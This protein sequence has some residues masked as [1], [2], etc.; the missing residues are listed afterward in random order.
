[1]GGQARIFRM[2]DHRKIQLCARAQRFAHDGFIED[3]LAVVRDSYCACF[4]QAAKI[5]QHGTFAVVG[6]GCD[7]ENINQGAALGLADPVY[8]FRGVNHGRGIRH[9]AYRREPASSG[10]GGAGR[11]RFLVTLAG[12]A[13]VN[14][15]VNEAGSDDQTAR[16]EFSFGVTPDFVRR[17]NLGHLAIAQQEVHGAIDPG[18][19]INDVTASDQEGRCFVLRH[20]RLLPPSTELAHFFIRDPAPGRG[21]NELGPP[22]L[23]SIGAGLIR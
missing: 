12:L 5:G 1:M 2:L 19:R 14:M 11:D 4:L 6:G 15:Q 18:G 17:C 21:A 10:G 7:W 3:R 16:V 8:P 20:D 23:R 9:A 13:Q 22:R